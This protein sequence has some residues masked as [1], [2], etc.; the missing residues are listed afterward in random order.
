MAVVLDSGL[1]SKVVVNIIKALY[2]SRVPSAS[3][4]VLLWTV[5]LWASPE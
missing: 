5:Q 1:R 4:Q 2:F 3:S